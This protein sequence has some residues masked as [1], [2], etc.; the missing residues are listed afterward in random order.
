MKSFTIIV[1]DW[2]LWVLTVYLLLHSAIALYDISI[3]WQL[4]KQRYKETK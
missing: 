1:P 3:N 4:I 2:I